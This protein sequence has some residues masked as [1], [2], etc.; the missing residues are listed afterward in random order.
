MDAHYR[1]ILEGS[2]PFVWTPGASYPP[3]FGLLTHGEIDGEPERYKLKW[4]S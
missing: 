1:Y 3:E 2:I 4:S